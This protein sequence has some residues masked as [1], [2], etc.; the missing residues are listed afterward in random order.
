MSKEER[1]EV[2][3]NTT[4]QEKETI[5]KELKKDRGIPGLD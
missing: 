4:I 5:I 3:Q 2:I 1:E